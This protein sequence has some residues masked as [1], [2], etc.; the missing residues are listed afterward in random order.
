[1]NNVNEETLPTLEYIIGMKLES[2]RDQDISDIAMI[3][4]YKDIKTPEKLQE[5]LIDLGFNDI[6]ESIMLEAFSEAYGIEW[7][8]NYYKEKE[9]EINK[10]IRNSKNGFYR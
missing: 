7:L 3:I 2:A 10:N 4:K 8:E 5:I 1:M 6:D 9:N